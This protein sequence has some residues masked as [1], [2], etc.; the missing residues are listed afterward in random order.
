MDRPD[1][2]QDIAMT[3]GILVVF[4]DMAA[5]GWQSTEE[6]LGSRPAP[7]SSFKELPE[8]AP[9]RGFVSLFVAVSTY[10]TCVAI[11]CHSWGCFGHQQAGGSLFDASLG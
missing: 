1:A 4:C 6:F 2:L 10:V 8:E 11:D 5:T 7:S 3:A 9:V